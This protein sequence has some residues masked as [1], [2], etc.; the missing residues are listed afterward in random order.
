MA[1]YGYHNRRGIISLVRNT[2]Q[3][4]GEY[5]TYKDHAAKW[6]LLNPAALYPFLYL[7]QLQHGNCFNRSWIA[8]TQSA[9]LIWSVR[10]SSSGCNGG[11]YGAE[12]PVKF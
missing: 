12:M 6:T 9:T 7:A 11:S 10:N 3:S 1:G 4:L 2:D 5:K 8:A